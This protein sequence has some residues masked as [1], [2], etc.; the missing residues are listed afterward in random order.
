[1]SKEVPSVAGISYLLPDFWPLKAKNQEQIIFWGRHNIRMMIRSWR[2]VANSLSERIKKQQKLINLFK[3]KTQAD[4]RQMAAKYKNPEFPKIGRAT[5]VGFSNEDEP[6]DPDSIN[7]QRGATTFNVCG[8]CDHAGGGSARF[9]YLISTSCSLKSKAGLKAKG[10]VFN[11]PCHWLTA[12][13][14]ELQRLVAGFSCEKGKLIAKKRKAD[15][16]IKMLR[17]LEGQAEAKPIFPSWR[18]F[19][20]FNLEHPIVLFLASWE[21]AI[22]P[23]L[24]VRGVVIPGWRHHDGCVSF[25]TEKKIHN[26]A[27][28]DGHGGGGA[29]SQSTIMEEWEFNYLVANPD[30]A[31]IW[32]KS[33]EKTSGQLKEMLKA[34]KDFQG[35]TFEAP[36]A[37]AT[38]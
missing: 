16:A 11:T 27:N 23:D 17:V 19:D 15:A 24:F 32:L 5:G 13:Q 22:V 25:Y 14:T 21:N 20:H 29:L 31:R 28:M 1:M 8:W 2:S 37:K 7:R 9:G 4:I 6:L 30:F 12:P 33:A 3:G 10:T 34:L 36:A 26:G 38:A 35:K 18:P